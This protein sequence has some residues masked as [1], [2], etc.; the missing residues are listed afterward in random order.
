MRRRGGCALPRPM[1]SCDMSCGSLTLSCEKGE[2]MAWQRRR[3]GHW[4]GR[5]MVAH[6]AK[7]LPSRAGGAR[8]G[9]CWGMQ[10]SPCQETQEAFEARS[11]RQTRG[12]GW[13]HG[14]ILPALQAEWTLVGMQHTALRCI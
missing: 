4:M 12:E 10:R 7:P 14:G 8:G 9:G 1:R 3:S 13:Q 2:P 5:G 6:A 11:A